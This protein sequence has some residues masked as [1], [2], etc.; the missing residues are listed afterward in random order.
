MGLKCA[1]CGAINAD[2]LIVCEYCNGDLGLK[3]GGSKSNKLIKEK[4]EIT[5]EFTSSLNTESF[6]YRDQ[7]TVALLLI[8]TCGIYYFVLLADWLKV[9]KKNKNL[10]GLLSVDPVQAVV[11]TII[12]CSAASIYF[13][14]KVAR[15]AAAITKKSGGNTSSIRKG[16]NPPLENLPEIILWGGIIS[17][18][19][20]IFSGGVLLFLDVIFAIWSTIAL[21]KSVEYMAGIKPNS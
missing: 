14:Y 19:I 7:G 16:L 6:E 3:N 9:I 4:G 2:N 1:Y 20:S 21:Q 5:N 10:Q 15:D 13:N 8:V 12:T 11:L 18:L 17:F